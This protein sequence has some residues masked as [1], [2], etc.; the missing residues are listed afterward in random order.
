[1]TKADLIKIGAAFSLAL[2]ASSA[3]AQVPSVSSGEGAAFGMLMLAFFLLSCALLYFVPT[4]VAQ[5]RKSSNTTTVFLVNLFLG[6]TAIGWIA[7]LVLAFAGDSGAQVRRHREM[8]EAL[9]RQDL[10]K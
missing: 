6:W 5:Y 4:A 3:F 8:M 2:A 7:A 10:E 9:R 1:M